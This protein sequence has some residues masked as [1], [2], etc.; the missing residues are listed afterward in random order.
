MT[1]L[2]S[3]LSQTPCWSLCCR[4]PALSWCPL[5][6]CVRL[7]CL[8]L[9]LVVPGFASLWQWVPMTTWILTLGDRR[10]PRGRGHGLARSGS[11][12]AAHMSSLY[13][14]LGQCAGHCSSQ[15]PGPLGRQQLEGKR[16]VLGEAQ[17][18]NR[19]LGTPEPGWVSGWQG[20]P[21]RPGT[22]HV[23]DA[24]RDGAQMPSHALAAPESVLGFPDT[25]HSGREGYVLSHN[26]PTTI[27]TSYWTCPFH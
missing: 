9:H 1:P 17:K 24:G 4:W 18:L 8:S 14:A 7:S 13:S 22:R 11:A 25:C 19:M 10:I 2:P 23:G 15:R 12:A 3:A 16:L 6:G 21:G 27:G 5:Q 26:R 20:W